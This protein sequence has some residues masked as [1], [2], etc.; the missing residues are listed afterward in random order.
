MGSWAGLGLLFPCPGVLPPASGLQALAHSFGV[1]KARILVQS[2]GSHRRGRVGAAEASG[3]SWAGPAGASGTRVGK[4]R[5]AVR[6]CL[7]WGS[8]PETQALLLV[9]ETL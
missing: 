6:V 5:L 9:A 1:W 2:Q 8:T 7:P 4:D 3:Q